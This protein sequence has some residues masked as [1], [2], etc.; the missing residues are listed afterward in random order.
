EDNHEKFT[1]D[2]KYIWCDRRG[3]KEDEAPSEYV[4]EIYP[5]T[6][7]PIV[8]KG[9]PCN[10]GRNT[11]CINWKGEMQ[12]C[13]VMDMYK[14]DLTKKSVREAW[15][16]IVKWSDEVPRIIECQNCIHRLNCRSCIAQ[17]YGDTGEFGKPSP[18]ICY[19]ILH[20]EEAAAFEER[21]KIH[22]EKMKND[23]EYQKQ[24][25]ERLRKFSKR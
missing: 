24:Y 4:N 21:Y 23:A 1:K 11:C 3:I 19:K 10:A 12:S 15:E 2:A 5:S 17:H 22:V 18:R 8:E 9:V 25:L 6:N 20:P 7:N 13:N 14:V 16:D